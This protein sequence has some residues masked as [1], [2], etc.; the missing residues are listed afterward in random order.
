MPPASSKRYQSR[1]FNFFN[2]HSQLW[3]KKVETTIRS[4]RVATKL[5]LES[6]LLPLYQALHPDQLLNKILQPPTTNKQRQL[7]FYTVPE[8]DQAIRNLLDLVKNLPSAAATETQTSQKLNPL[9]FLGKV[10][11]KVNA[12][13]GF[14][15]ASV[16]QVSHPDTLQNYIPTIQGIAVK[17]ETRNLVL[18]SSNNKIFDVLTIPQQN[19]IT[20]NINKEI[21]KLIQAPKVEEVVDEQAAIPKIERL[22]NKLTNTNEI[23]ITD[24][25]D[26]GNQSPIKSYPGKII[27]LLDQVL[28][29]LESKA[30]IPIQNQSQEIINILVDSK[31]QGEITVNSQGLQ[32][33]KLR[34]S[35]I[36]ESAINYF[37]GG[38]RIPTIAETEKFYELPQQTVNKFTETSQ[39]QTSENTD[40]WLTWSDLYGEVEIQSSQKQTSGKATTK[41]ESSSYVNLGNTQNIKDSKQW[42]L[43]PDW[44]ETKAIFIGYE[45]HP[46]E[47]ILEWLDHI[48]VWVEMIFLNM[49]YFCKGLFQLE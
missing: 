13:L 10:W 8:S 4:V 42:K 40:S 17:I 3:G 35:E 14:S 41:S 24:N 28:A 29:K 44:I 5:R 32:K 48:M 20:E 47:Q 6:L 16:N 1:V 11:G 21:E 43:N 30:I 7:N 23:R 22:L 36:I 45:K 37:F 9:G 46:L 33:P 2:Q 26:V 25:V 15:A 27:A 38:R 18:V 34:I 12:K 39:I 31:D 49:V 19:I